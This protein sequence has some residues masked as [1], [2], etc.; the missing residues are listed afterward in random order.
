VTLAVGYWLRR[1]DA[2]WQAEARERW[3]NSD[4]FQREIVEALESLPTQNLCR[5][6]QDYAALTHDLEVGCAL[7]DIPCWMARL[8]ATGRVPEECQACELFAA[9]L[10]N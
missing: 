7:L 1:L 3:K 6:A 8:R 2:R 10:V 4:P 5:K 9:S